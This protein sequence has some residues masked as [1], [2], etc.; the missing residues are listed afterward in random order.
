M[1]VLNHFSQR[2]LIWA[3]MFAILAVLL[4]TA[5]TT[6]AAPEQSCGFY[7]FVRRGET[8]NMISR[9]YGVSVDAILRANPQIKNQNVIYAGTNI[10]IPCGRPPGHPGYPGQP[11]MG[12]MCHQ[13]HYVSYGQT[14]SQI[15]SMYH[16]PPYKLMQANGL[17][18]PNL[19]FAGT[20]LCI[21]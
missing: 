3:L 12:G 10:Y 7:H 21:P 19:I 16:V 17:H 8:L 5:A 9:Q 6:E 20:Y 18:N 2:K 4:L 14:L 13:W 15:A 11:G 1:K